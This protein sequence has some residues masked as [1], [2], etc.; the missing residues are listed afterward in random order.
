V[1]A[2]TSRTLPPAQLADALAEIRRS[3]F[4]TNLIAGIV[5]IFVKAAL[6]ASLTLFL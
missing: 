6:C 1:L 5:A 3:T 2:E 4:Q